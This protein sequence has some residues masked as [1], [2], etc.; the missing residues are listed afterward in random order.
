M[1]NA[2]LFGLSVVLA[3]CELVPGAT[4]F[5][6]DFANPPWDT[7]WSIWP[8]GQWTP[9]YWPGEWR[10]PYNPHAKLKDGCSMWTTISTVGYEDIE[11]SFYALVAFGDSPDDRLRI[12][13]GTPSAWE[14]SETLAWPDTGWRQMTFSLPDS[15]ARDS[16]IR[17]FF[18][19]TRDYSQP[20]HTIYGAVDDVLVTG[21]PIQ[22]EAIPVPGAILLGT[23]GAGFVGWLRRRRTV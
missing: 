17:M 22:Q 15:W 5:F 23:I 8:N 13:L 6:D 4:I 3:V 20:G 19:A 1:R 16:A 21:R 7:G 10:Y 2:V 11:V 18:A 14:Y 9:Y 12:D